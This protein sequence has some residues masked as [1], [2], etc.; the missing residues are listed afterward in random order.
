LVIIFVFLTASVLFPVFLG[1]VSLSGPLC[2]DAFKDTTFFHRVVGLGM[3]LAWSFQRFVVVFLVVSPSIGTLACVYLVIIVVRSLASE[4]VTII[5]MPVP[6]FSVVVVIATA[7]IPVVETPTA[8]ISS[9]RL[10][11]SSYVFSDE[12]FCV[13]GIGV[14]LAVARSLATMVG[15]LRSNLLLNASCKRRPL[16]KADMASSWEIFGILRR[17]SEKRQM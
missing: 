3:E 6:P 9:G 2:V 17:I 7:G 1:G 14:V 11:G 16:M 15:L 5:T 4:I 13:V 8:I 12:F 10:L